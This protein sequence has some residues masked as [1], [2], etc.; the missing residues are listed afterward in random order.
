MEIGV[1]VLPSR[2]KI[3]LRRAASLMEKVDFISIPD[4]PFG[5]PAPSSLMLATLLK[6]IGMKSIPNYRLADRN[7]LSFLSEMMGIREMGLDRI[8]LVGGDPPTI[9]KPTNLE[10]VRA[11]SLLR[12]WGIDLE[13]GVAS[14]LKPSDRVKMKL[15]AGA[16][17]VVTQP[18]QRVED[19]IPLS[20]FIGDTPL[21]AMIMPTLSELEDYI[22]KAMDIEE[23]LEVDY[24]ALLDDLKESGLVRGVV[25]SV[26]R[27][28]SKV[29]EILG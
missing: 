6:F 1:E 27:R 19:L 14:S 28:P 17:F 22:L 26:P 16:D 15:E 11:I 18:V 4:S 13:V 24:R 29:H 10:P 3:F 5:R 23:V 9:G 7:E 25:I 21:Y 20:D 2:K 8:L 12:E